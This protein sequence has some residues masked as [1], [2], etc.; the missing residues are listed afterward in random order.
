MFDVTLT[1]IDFKLDFVNQDED[2]L[3]NARPVEP[4]LDIDGLDRSLLS[5]LL[6]L[7]GLA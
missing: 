2:W 1:D 7:F 4:D 5:R 3:Q 6:A